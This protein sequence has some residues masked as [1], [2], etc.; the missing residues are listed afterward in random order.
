MNIYI[1]NIIAMKKIVLTED[2]LNRM[3]IN[4]GMYDQ[5]K[6]IFNDATT[7]QSIGSHPAA[8]LDYD[9]LSGTIYNAI[10]GMGT[11]EDEVLSAF[12]Q[13]PDLPSLKKLISTFRSVYG[14]DL[15]GWLDDDFDTERSWNTYIYQPILKAKRA[16]EAAKHYEVKKAAEAEAVNP[17]LL[18]TFKETFP[19]IEQTPGFSPLKTDSSRN[20]LKFESDYGTVALNLDGSAWIWD[21]SKWNKQTNKISCPKSAADTE[22]SEELIN[23]QGLTGFNQQP[24]ASSTTPEATGTT[25][26]TSGTTTGTTDATSGTTTGDWITSF[27]TQLK[28][29][30]YGADLGTTGAN[31]DGVDGK[32]GAKTAT[33]AY[34][35][36]KAKG[37]IN[38]V[39]LP[40]NLNE[41]FNNFKRLIK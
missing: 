6:A 9:G 17:Q 4:E 32:L 21:G 1:E 24:A 19:C 27:Q 31:G 15:L 13:I 28:N 30:G 20:Q 8:S 5:I 26:A 3:V 14:K 7:N 35:L 25:D 12:S 36:L 10:K 37:I 2:Q 23:E 11:D 40:D 33:A 16:S 29:A 38:E 34:K 39:A 41:T 22:V 18:Q